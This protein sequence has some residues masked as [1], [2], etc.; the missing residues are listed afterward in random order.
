[1]VEEVYNPVPLMSKLSIQNCQLKLGVRP[2]KRLQQ[3][4]CLQHLWQALN[5]PA[6]VI[7]VSR[8]HENSCGNAGSIQDR[9]VA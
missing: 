5:H 9:Q 1:M 3:Q 7:E 6:E 2:D 4:H 8:K